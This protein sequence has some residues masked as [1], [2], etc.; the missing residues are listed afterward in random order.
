MTTLYCGEKG[1]GTRISWN[2]SVKAAQTPRKTPRKDEKVDKSVR[3]CR[4]TRKDGIF[5]FLDL[6][7]GIAKRLFPELVPGR[8]FYPRGRGILGYLTLAGCQ[9]DAQSR[10]L[11]VIALGIGAKSTKVIKPHI[12]H[13]SSRARSESYNFRLPPPESRT[14]VI[15]GRFTRLLSN[16]YPESPYSHPGLPSRPS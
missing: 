12:L 7:A 15:M 6:L 1:L 10:I 16:C 14:S 9:K 11:S 2:K 4:F 5:H 3:K 8:S 13:L